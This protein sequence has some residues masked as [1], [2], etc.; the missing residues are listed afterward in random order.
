MD[1]FSGVDETLLNWLI[2]P[3]FIFTAR[4][5]DVS[6]GTV[7]IILVGKGIRGFAALLGFIEVL[8][9]IIAIGQIMQNLSNF[10]NYIAYAGGFSCGTYVGVY[11]EN[12]ISI[13]KVVVRIITRRDATELYEHLIENNYHLTMLDAEGRF[14]D[15]KI[16]YL[17]LKRKEVTK[18]IQIINSYNSR[19]FYTIEDIRF[20]NDI[21]AIPKLNPYLMRLGNLRKVFTLRK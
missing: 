4:V 14:G 9:W 5:I 2:L 17:V 13:G 19:S 15:V 8:I 10:L 21:D 3:L 18:L 11:L 6:I 16:I 1:I 20:V 7:R 12:K